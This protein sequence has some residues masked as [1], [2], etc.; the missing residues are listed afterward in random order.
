MHDEMA[1]SVGKPRTNE[2]G[3]KIG[4]LID[5]APPVIRQRLNI[6]ARAQR[7]HGTRIKSL[8]DAGSEHAQAGIGFGVAACRQLQLGETTADDAPQIDPDV[9]LVAAGVDDIEVRAGDARQKY[10]VAHRRLTRSNQLRAP[11]ETFQVLLFVLVEQPIDFG[12][13][14]VRLLPRGAADASA[15]SRRSQP[16]ST[17]TSRSAV[18]SMRP[19]FT[20]RFTCWGYFFFDLRWAMVIPEYV[21]HL[22]W[23]RCG[24]QELCSGDL[25]YGAAGPVDNGSCNEQR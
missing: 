19:G 16:G 22:Q 17:R 3:Q 23:R 9:V 13:R 6:P 12:L 8:V 10:D 24:R 25:F 7:H 14:S 2:I 1:R 4:R 20:R 18:A 5:I 15:L 11:R 21:R